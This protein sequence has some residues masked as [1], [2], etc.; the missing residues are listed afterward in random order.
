MIQVNIVLTFARS[1]LDTQESLFG[2][3]EFRELGNILGTAADSD[4]FLE[5]FQVE[6]RFDAGEDCG[7]QRN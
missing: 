1:G 2:I 4:P 5:K 3:D 6:Q 7:L